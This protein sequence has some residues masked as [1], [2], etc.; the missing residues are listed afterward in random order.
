MSRPPALAAL[1]IVL[2]A[3][4]A[5]AQFGG[6]GADGNLKGW[7]SWSVQVETKNDTRVAGTLVLQSVKV[8]CDLGILEIKADKL[9][10]VHFTAD[11]API[12]GPEGTRLR[13]DIV[14][15]SG[16]TVKGTLI[17]PELKMKTD[18]GT[19]TLAPQK[20]R[21][22]TFNGPDGPDPKAEG[23]K[24]GTLELKPDFKP[25]SSK[26][27]ADEGRPARP[28]PI[29]RYLTHPS[30]SRVMRIGAFARPESCCLAPSNPP[31]HVS[32]QVP[33]MKRRVIEP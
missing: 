30:A 9:K 26:P 19:L 5:H 17:V 14:T 29:P 1:A 21:S 18:L 12:I 6:A 7:P 28:S 32:A 25:E 13:G 20:L 31:A 33:S 22:I 4:S 3:L 15:A 24:P 27:A 16:S 8:D 2:A 10:V 23:P 11:D